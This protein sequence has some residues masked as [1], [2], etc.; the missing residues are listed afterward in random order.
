MQLQQ[1]TILL[2]IH[3]HSCKQLLVSLVVGCFFSWWLDVMLSC[4]KVVSWTRHNGPHRVW[5]LQSLMDFVS[6]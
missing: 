2:F 4:I 1:D 5:E 3:V 6:S